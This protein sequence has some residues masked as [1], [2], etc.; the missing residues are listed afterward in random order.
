M[1]QVKIPRRIAQTVLNSLKGGV[2]PRIG[3]PYIAVGRKNEIAALLHD[4]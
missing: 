3:L 2:V 1:E 4:V